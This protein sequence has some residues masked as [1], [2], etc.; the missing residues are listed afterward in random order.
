MMSLNG[1]NAKKGEVESPM[2]LTVLGCGKPVKS[3]NLF[4]ELRA[5]GITDKF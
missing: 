5:L 2:T 4:V 3:V 1:F